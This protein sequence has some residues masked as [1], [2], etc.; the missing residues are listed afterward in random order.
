[1]A[2]C[3]NAVNLRKR[4]LNRVDVIVVGAG[5]A[6]AT[7]ARLLALRKFSVLLVDKAI[8]P[9]PKLCGGLLTSK[10]VDLLRNFYDEKVMAETY[11]TISREVFFFYKQQEICR[12]AV[13]KPLFFV[14]RQSFDHALVKQ[15]IDAGCLFKDGTACCSLDLEKHEATLSD[16]SVI[17]FKIAIGADGALSKIRRL[18]DPTYLP[19]GFCLETEEAGC[20][21]SGIAPKILFGCIPSGYAWLFPCGIKTIKG[22]GSPLG[23]DRGKHLET[24]ARVFPSIVKRRPIGALVPF[25]K[26]VKYPTSG[27]DL[28]LVGDAAG[29]VDPLTGEGIYFAVLS[30]VYAAEAIATASDGADISKVYLKKIQGIHKTISYMN[31]ARRAFHSR[32]IHKTFL[33][34]FGKSPCVMKFFCDHLVSSYDFCPTKP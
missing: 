5:P 32:Y 1:M 4:F 13:K 24:F 27:N 16:K 22:I 33:S 30:G 6:G 20:E 26:Y 2:L 21:E 28:F 25:G 17:K 23:N 12:V 9:R 11:E 19:G 10:T 14:N 3:L 34:T 15:A 8:F 7:C 31:L 29:L 18:I